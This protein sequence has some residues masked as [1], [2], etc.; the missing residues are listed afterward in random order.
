[1]WLAARVPHLVHGDDLAIDRE[2]HAIMRKALNA[3]IT[4]RLL[5]HLPE[6][7]TH[8]VLKAGVLSGEEAITQTGLLFLVPV[9]DR[10]GLVK[11]NLPHIE[12][13]AFHFRPARNR[14]I[15]SSLV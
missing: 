5:P 12:R 1:M 14:R 7:T 15:A 13:E 11:R 9:T 4:E 10:C 6:R 2:H 3:R 8:Q